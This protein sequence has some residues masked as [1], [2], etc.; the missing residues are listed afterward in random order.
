M[1]GHIPFLSTTRTGS[2]T[3]SNNGLYIGIQSL[4]IYAFTNDFITAQNGTIKLYTIKLV[5]IAFRYKMNNPNF[6]VATKW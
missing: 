4:A 1:L 3:G 5:L 2:A 6:I